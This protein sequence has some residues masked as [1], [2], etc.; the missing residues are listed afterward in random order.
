MSVWFYPNIFCK[1]V[2]DVPLWDLCGVNIIYTSTQTYKFNLLE[3]RQKAHFQTKAAPLS[4]R[5]LVM[6]LQ[7]IILKHLKLFVPWSLSRKQHVCF[8]LKPRGVLNNK[9]FIGLLLSQMS[10]KE[11]VIPPS[12][13]TYRGLLNPE[14][15]CVSPSCST[16]LPPPTQL[17]ISSCSP[18]DTHIF[19]TNLTPL[20]LLEQLE[21]KTLQ[22][23]SYTRITH[24]H[25]YCSDKVLCCRFNVTEPLWNNVQFI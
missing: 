1:T 25:T 13:W 4:V 2:R 5:G 10:M 11:F 12:G 15:M 7:S 8:W 14:C 21:W 18:L 23:F 9:S 24:T 22:M 19:L 16:V 6:K 3:C 20:F 17:P